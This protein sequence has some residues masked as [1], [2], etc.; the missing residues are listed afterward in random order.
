MNDTPCNCA[1][2]CFD[3]V[4]SA[5]RQKVFDGFW[6][7]NSFDIQN[8]YL[9]GCIRVLDVKRRYTSAGETSR[10]NYS[11]VFYISVGGVSEGVCKTAFLHIHGVSNGRVHRVIKG[12]QDQGVPRQDQRGRHTPANKTKEE[13]LADIRQHISSF[14]KYKSHYSREDNPHREYLSPEL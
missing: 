7:M 2:K 8:A 14:P 6:K 3:H 5:Q 12:Q 10:R 11:R 9:C 1:L 4:T 13:D